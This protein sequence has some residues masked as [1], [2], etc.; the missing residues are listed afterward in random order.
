MSPE[1][2]HV[3]IVDDECLICDMVISRLKRL[4]L[5]GVGEVRSCESG[6]QA[7]ALCRTYK[8]HLVMTD[9][10]MGGMEGIEL[11]ERLAK[12]L[13][14]VRFIVLSGYDD[15]DLVRRAF[16]AGAFD[17][18]LKPVVPEAL[19]RVVEAALTSL[20]TDV[21][22]DQLARHELF[23]LGNRMIALAGN[24]AMRDD[25]KQKVYKRINAMLGQGMLTGM[26]FGFNHVGA[27]R[28][29]TTLVN[30]VYDVLEGRRALCGMNEHG[31]LFVLLGDCAASD[32]STLTEALAKESGA[33][34]LVGV[35]GA[36][37]LDS[38]AVVYGKS[39]WALT[40]RAGPAPLAL[41]DLIQKYIEQNYEQGI[42]LAQVAQ[43]FNISYTH[44]S[45]LFKLQFHMSFIEFLTNV[46]MTKA[47]TLLSDTQ[48]SIQEIAAG[49]GYNNVF[50]FSRAY[51]KRFGVAP[52]YYRKSQQGS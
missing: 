24:E 51:K 16:I 37:T 28:D 49:C 41:P 14:P 52:S 19:Q 11:I 26:M 13:Y 9:I 31:R 38:L 25:E 35:G 5:P 4:N 40:Q 36:G 44:L 12:M 20:E 47:M 46:R 50:H 15:F 1:Q 48:L 42:T 8:P 43:Q 39:S 22:R 17:Y 6:E 27:Q 10:R 34:V 33:D 3:L 30:M 7:A 21:S 45:K 23:E 2:H 29:A 18:L 32:P